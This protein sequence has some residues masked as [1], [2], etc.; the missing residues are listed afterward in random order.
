MAVPGPLG[1]LRMTVDTGLR[2]YLH[3]GRGKSA[4]GSSG[5]SAR[6]DASRGSACTNTDASNHAPSKL[7]T[8]KLVPATR[9]NPIWWRSAR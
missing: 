9:L 1:F 5:P 7:K 6:S 4:P 3:D 2:Q 8:A